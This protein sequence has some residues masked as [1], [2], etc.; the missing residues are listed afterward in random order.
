MRGQ[1]V[2][3]LRFAVV[4]GLM[5]GLAMSL[6]PA[7]AQPRLDA[8]D[9]TRG[10]QIAESLCATCHAP[11]ADRGGGPANADIMSFQAIARRGA[12]P[13]YLA[14]RI[15]IPHP[16]MPDTQLKVSEIRDVIAYIL[17][18]RP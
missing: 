16:P 1:Q 12:S 9:A 6:S 17:S 5:G 7:Q 14:G 13:E 3:V 15:I 10:R 11:A 18:L 2:K 4:G 8:G